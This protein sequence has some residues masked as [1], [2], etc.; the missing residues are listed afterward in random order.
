MRSIRNP[1]AAPL[2]PSTFEGAAAK[3][4]FS[5]SR[6]LSYLTLIIALTRFPST[7]AVITPRWLITKYTSR[8]EL[9]RFHL[10]PTPS[11]RM[12][13][14]LGTFTKGKFNVRD[15]VLVRLFR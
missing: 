3:A 5:A 13:V 2:P 4:V 15:P 8:Y 9:Y 14:S 7:R 12:F 11:V 1:D 6:K 10:V